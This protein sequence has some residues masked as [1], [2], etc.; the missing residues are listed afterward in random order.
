MQILP[1]LLL[2][3]TALLM[4]WCA[5]VIGAR[6]LEGNPGGE[7]R[8]VRWVTASARNTVVCVLSIVALYS[9]VLRLM[10]YRSGSISE[11]GVMQY[12][13]SLLVV[14]SMAYLAAYHLRRML[15]RYVVVAA[16]ALAA[17]AWLLWPNWL[18]ID[19][20]VVL[21]GVSLLVSV[22]NVSA[23]FRFAIT[24]SGGMFLYDIL[25]VYITEWMQDAVAPTFEVQAPMLLLAPK[26][27]SL[28][29]GT[30]NLLGLGDVLVPGFIIMTAA[31]LAYRQGVMSL[32]YGG[33]AG[34]AVGLSLAGLLAF[35][36]NQLQP[37][38]ITLYPCTVAGI[39]LAAWRAGVVRA[40]FEQRHVPRLTR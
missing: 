10:S 17:S 39:L 40:L 29:A 12:A 18:T 6:R 28:E 14:A 26:S 21:M 3:V 8:L 33:L 7:Y 5:A 2:L 30:Q 4:I 37:A 19:V 27:L 31:V 9:V 23:S 22:V 36:F 11:M 24:F 35:V 32:L 38:L 13:L 20:L 1:S 15:W 16:F 34:Y 25:H